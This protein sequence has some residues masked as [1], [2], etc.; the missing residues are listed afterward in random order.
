[1]Q[2]KPPTQEIS[3]VEEDVAAK[4]HTNHDKIVNGEI[5]LSEKLLTE[6]RDDLSRLEC[7]PLYREYT[8]GNVPTLAV[9]DVSTERAVHA[10]DATLAGDRAKGTP[11]NDLAEE[12]KVRNLIAGRSISIKRNV[13][14]YIRTVLRFHTLKRLAAGGGRDMQEQFVKTDEARVRAHNNLIK[15][16]QIMTS[17]IQSA[18][19]MNLLPEHKILKWVAGMNAHDLN[20]NPNTVVVFSDKVM[21]DRDFI[22]DWAIAADFDLQLQEMLATQKR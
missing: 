6:I 17:T 13:A 21:Q 20:K 3:A 12:T 4:I 14:E 18:A 15:S 16:L 7:Y 5:P 2:E 22:K 8:A 10:I 9:L 19:T 11:E 1:M